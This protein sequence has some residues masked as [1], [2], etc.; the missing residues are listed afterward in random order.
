MKKAFSLIELLIVIVI[1]GLLAG[2]IIPNVV[3]KGEQAK[4]RLA[5]VQMKSLVQSLELFRQDNGSYPQT[6]E[7]LKALAIN[8]DPEKYPDF[9]EG[10]YVTGKKIPKDPW[11]NAY[12]YVLGEDGFE[13]ISLGSDK[14][15]GGT[16]DKKDIKLSTCQ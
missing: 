11:K 7:G 4:Q 15:E 5:C 10:G 16:G 12:I 6:E 2:L 3:N 13:I 8:P 14:K 1:L 9:L